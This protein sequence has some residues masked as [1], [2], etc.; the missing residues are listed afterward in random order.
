MGI[1]DID[2]RVCNMRGVREVGYLLRVAGRL[3]FCRSIV[4][5]PQFWCQ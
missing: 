3:V 5:Q 2:I 1:G 4:D